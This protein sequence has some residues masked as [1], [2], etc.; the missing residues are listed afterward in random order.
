MS[1]IPLSEIFASRPSLAVLLLVRGREVEDPFR[2]AIFSHATC[3]PR[4]MS[5]LAQSFDRSIASSFCVACVFVLPSS[6]HEG[7]LPRRLPSTAPQTRKGGG[8]Y[9][10]EREK[11]KDDGVGRPA[12]A[13]SSSECYKKMRYICEDCIQGSKIA[14]CGGSSTPISS[15]AR[16]VLQLTS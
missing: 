10:N 1:S 2:F 11:R 6:R 5:G 13:S 8:R 9:Q 3:R 16:L 7:R 4:W 14:R 12:G 15:R